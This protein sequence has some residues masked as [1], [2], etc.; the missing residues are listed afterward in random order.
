MTDLPGLVKF[1]DWD[2]AFFG[3]RIGRVLP[4]HLSPAEIEEIDNWSKS[5]GMDCLYFLSASSGGEQI[6][7]ITQSG[8][9]MMDIRI[10]LQAVLNSAKPRVSVQTG[11]SIASSSDIASLRHI[12]SMNHSDTRFY[13]DTHFERARCDEL[14]ATWIEKSVRD[15]GQK[16]YIYKPEREALGYI[17]TYCTENHSVVGLVGIAPVCQGKGIGSKLL[18]RALAGL[19]EEGSAKA[20]VVTQG[21]NI[22]AIQFYEKNGFKI[23]SIETWFHKWYK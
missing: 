9:L 1:L 3:K 12:A 22:K 7:L 23:K 19:E 14:Y 4:K 10:T 6:F 15:P 2:S 11:F 5:E 8:Y 21:S 16:V 13:T 17:S 18:Q 20:E